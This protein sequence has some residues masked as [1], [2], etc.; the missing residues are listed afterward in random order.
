MCHAVSE[1][2]QST[3]FLHTSHVT[4]LLHLLFSL[5]NFTLLSHMHAAAGSPDSR[6]PGNRYNSNDFDFSHTT[7]PT[8]SPT[9]LALLLAALSAILLGAALSWPTDSSSPGADGRLRPLGFGSKSKSGQSALV[10]A[11]WNPSTS[12]W[13]APAPWDPEFVKHKDSMQQV[14]TAQHSTERHST[15]RHDGCLH[16]LICIDI[17]VMS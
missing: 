7:A 9:R 11:W 3:A 15:A 17:Y 14:S 8:S 10:D 16:V 2:V 13:E 5:H 1:H 6:P 4:F 12:R